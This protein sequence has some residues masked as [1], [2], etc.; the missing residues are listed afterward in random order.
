MTD[1]N[2]STTNSNSPVSFLTAAKVISDHSVI[3]QFYS[4]Y[5]SELD[6]PYGNCDIHRVMLIAAVSHFLE[7]VAN[8]L[9]ELKIEFP[10]EFFS[11]NPVNLPVD[12]TDEQQELLSDYLRCNNF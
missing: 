2:N 8:L 10:V 5:F 3:N 4:D 11:F 6:Y 7:S 1:K 9:T 12:L